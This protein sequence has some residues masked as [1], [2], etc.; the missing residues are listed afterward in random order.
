MDFLG[1]LIGDVLGDV[2]ADKAGKGLRRMRQ[3]LGPAAGGVGCALKIVS[4]S[5]DGLSQHWRL[6]TGQFA[7]GELRFT[8]HGHARPPITVLGA[9]ETA[10]RPRIPSLGDCVIAQLQTPTATL[11]LAMLAEPLA[12]AVHE[13]T[14][15]AQGT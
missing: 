5:Q 4:G 12:L 3:R 8:Q 2:V 9:R 15:S 11:A 6:G 1:D 13:L 10:D 14:R 7:P